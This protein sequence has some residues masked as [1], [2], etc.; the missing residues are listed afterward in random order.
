MS[1]PSVKVASSFP[2]LL[3]EALLAPINTT[4]AG[5]TISYPFAWTDTTV[6]GLWASH[7]HCNEWTST[8]GQGSLG[9][10]WSTR[11]DWAGPAPS[12][13]TRTACHEAMRLYCVEQ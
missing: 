5:G 7:A 6:A 11:A 2:D 10:G 1:D 12:T 8:T 13:Q 4:E 9:L 3:D